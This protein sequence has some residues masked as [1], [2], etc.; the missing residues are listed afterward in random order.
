MKLHRRTQ[1]QGESSIQPDLPSLFGPTRQQTNALSA[2]TVTLHHQ[3][4]AA[5]RTAADLQAP[6]PPRQSVSHCPARH[7]QFG[8]GVIQLQQWL[9]TPT[10]QQFQQSFRQGR[11]VKHATIQQHRVRG[12]RTIGRRPFAQCPPGRVAV[13]RQKRR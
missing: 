12:R 2:A 4:I 6:T 9:T 10:G 1:P 5:R 8:F 7:R 3:K 11:A 13:P